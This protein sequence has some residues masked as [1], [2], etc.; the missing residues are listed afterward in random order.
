MISFLIIAK[1][2]DTKLIFQDLTLKLAFCIQKAPML[3]MSTRMIPDSGLPELP[4]AGRI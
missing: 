3:M 4:F 1:T 2:E